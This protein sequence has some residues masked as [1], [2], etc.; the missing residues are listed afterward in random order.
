MIRSERHE[1]C[2]GEDDVLKRM[3]RWGC[4][5]LIVSY[6]EVVDDAFSVQVVI[7]DRKEVPVEGLAPG[8]FLLRRLL[9]IDGFDRKESSDLAVNRRLA[10]H[11]EQNH[12]SMT[13][14]EQPYRR[15]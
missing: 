13:E 2:I 10:D 3:V 11:N 8:I 5:S 6:L 12:I 4:R 7:G 15:P 14:Q 9:S 1:L